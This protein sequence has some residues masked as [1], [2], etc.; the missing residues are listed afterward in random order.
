MLP[1]TS[2]AVV[3]VVGAGV[4]R[5]I[6]FECPVLGHRGAAVDAEADDRPLATIHHRGPRDLGRCDVRVQRRRAVGVPVLQ[7]PKSVPRYEEKG[8]R[9]E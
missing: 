3:L 7:D 8:V 6:A 1:R 2:T 4:D 9:G 5:R